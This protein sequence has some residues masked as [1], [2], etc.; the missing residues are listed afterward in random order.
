MTS[1]GGRADQSLHGR[2]S[3]DQKATAETV[4]RAGGR[5]DDDEAPETALRGLAKLETA[6][7]SK[8]EPSN[9]VLNRDQTARSGCVGGYPA[10]VI[11]SLAPVQRPVVESATAVPLW[12]VEQVICTSRVVYGHSLDG[13]DNGIT[14]ATSSCC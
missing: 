3:G 7:V 11:A 5:A 4:Q 12:P 1:A 13:L 6:P 14:A 9:P 8:R 2:T 10:D